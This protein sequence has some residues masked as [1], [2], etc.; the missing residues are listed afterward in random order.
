MSDLGSSIE[1]S[2]SLS[3]R[4]TLTESDVFPAWPRSEFDDASDRGSEL[5]TGWI[6]ESAALRSEGRGVGSNDC[7]SDMS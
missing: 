3:F 5:V 6:P 1:I 7:V 2:T 4:G